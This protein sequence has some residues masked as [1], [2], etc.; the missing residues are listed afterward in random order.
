MD[1]PTHQKTIYSNWKLLPVY[2]EKNSSIVATQPTGFSLSAKDVVNMI[3]RSLEKSQEKYLS[4]ELK[5]SGN[6]IVLRA[7]DQLSCC[8][9]FYNENGNGIIEFQRRFG[10]GFQFC[11]FY[12]EVKS[13]M[14]NDY[15]DIFSV[16][17]NTVAKPLFKPVPF[18]FFK[19]NFSNDTLEK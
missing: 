18:S 14:M 9:H 13:I 5:P 1:N 11:N 8:I 4:F 19:E 6:S 3:K 16:A 7:R 12:N 10:C 2:F 17:F 15:P